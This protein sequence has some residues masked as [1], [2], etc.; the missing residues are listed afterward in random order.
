MQKIVLT[1]TPI[2]FQTRP[3]CIRTNVNFIFQN[4]RV[5]CQPN[6]EA[7]IIY[8]EAKVFLELFHAAY[9]Y[10]YLLFFYNCSTFTT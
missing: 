8:I 9:I 6:E 3:N 10:S 2:F 4:M 5:S 1:Q 7:L